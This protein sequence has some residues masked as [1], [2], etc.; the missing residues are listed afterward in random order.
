MKIFNN[1]M[2]YGP[3]ESEFTN[4]LRTSFKS[5]LFNSNRMP[6]GNSIRL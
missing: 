4:D 2:L 3:S 1:A 6:N 5:D